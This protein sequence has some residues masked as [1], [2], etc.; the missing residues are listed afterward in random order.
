[1]PGAVYGA[2]SAEP[3]AIWKDGKLLDKDGVG[4]LLQRRGA[5][6]FVGRA[7]TASWRQQGNV[8][9]AAGSSTPHARLVNGQW[10]KGNTYEVLYR[11]VG[12]ALHAG[13]GAA[14]VL[15]GEGLGAEELFLA[16]LALGK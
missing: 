9:F 2:G 16:A 3:L 15:R 5:E 14:P 8:V 1:V 12:S 4:T 13:G 11:V 7:A 6:W 10:L